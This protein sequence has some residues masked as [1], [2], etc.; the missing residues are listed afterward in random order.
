[1]NR[2]LLSEALS[3]YSLVSAEL[4]VVQK[5]VSRLH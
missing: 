5:F 3:V 2:A 1:M 4:I